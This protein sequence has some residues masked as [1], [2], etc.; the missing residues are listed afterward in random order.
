MPVTLTARGQGTE[1]ERHPDYPI[2]LSANAA[3]PETAWEMIHRGD[4]Q[5]RAAIHSSRRHQVVSREQQQRRQQNVYASIQKQKSRRT[6]ETMP[7]RW[8]TRSS[9]RCRRSSFEDGLLYLRDDRQRK[10]SDRGLHCLQTI[11][12][13]L[14]VSAQKRNIPSDAKPVLRPAACRKAVHFASASFGPQSVAL[15]QQFRRA[16]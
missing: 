4:P 3:I 8:L 9:C 6:I 10:P 14:I 15:R 12:S 7:A 2:L 11:A 1:A 5:N 16:R 13:S